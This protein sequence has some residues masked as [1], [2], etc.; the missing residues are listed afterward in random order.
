MKKAV[1][2]T[3]STKIRKFPQIGHDSFGTK[4]QRFWQAL[5]SIHQY[6]VDSTSV[7]GFSHLRESNGFK[8]FI[9]L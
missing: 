8:R 4:R 3:H 1:T 7:H 6:Y 2:V 9:I 5:K